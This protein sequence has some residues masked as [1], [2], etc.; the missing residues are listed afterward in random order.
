MEQD[1]T[2]RSLFRDKSLPSR[3]PLEPVKEENSESLVRRKTLK[4]LFEKKIVNESSVVSCSDK[5]F[6]IFEPRPNRKPFEKIDIM[7][8]LST[9][10]VNVSR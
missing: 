6:D 3:C 8:R 1:K 10:K 5:D 4:R 9:K 2:L 7:K